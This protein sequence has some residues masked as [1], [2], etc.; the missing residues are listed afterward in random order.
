MTKNSCR[1]SSNWPN[2]DLNFF[3]IKKKQKAKVFFSFFLLM[4]LFFLYV[5]SGSLLLLLLLL[6]FIVIRRKNQI[7]ISII[8]CSS[9]FLQSTDRN[10]N[11]FGTNSRCCTCRTTLIIVL[12][13]QRRIISFCVLSAVVFSHWI[14]ERSRI[15]DIELRRFL[16]Q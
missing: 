1:S 14:D 10:P 12:K 4:H 5:F 11:G 16:P 15:I 6:C 9:R 7:F 8:N 3:C 2:L 13:K